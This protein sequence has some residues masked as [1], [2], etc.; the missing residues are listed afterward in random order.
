MRRRLAIA[1]AHFT[2]ARR[3]FVATLLAACFFTA[4]AGLA[5]TP[6]TDQAGRAAEARSRHV[7][8]PFGLRMYA[9]EFSIAFADHDSAE[10]AEL[11]ICPL[12]HD[13]RWAFSGRWDD[14]NNR[15]PDMKELMR[16]HGYKATF[17]L[18]SYSRQAPFAILKYVRT[19][20][21]LLAQDGFSVGG[22]TLQHP[23]LSRVDKNQL[24][25][26]IAADRV[27][28]ECAVGK[29]VN[30]FAFP[31]S[32]F[33]Q[34]KTTEVR[35]DIAEALIRAGYLHTVTSAFPREEIDNRSTL[36]QSVNLINP[37][38]ENPDPAR[39]D[40]QLNG[41]LGNAQTQAVCPNMTVGIH[42]QHT[43]E[44]LVKLE[45]CL[46]RYAGNRG[47]WYCNQTEYAAYRHQYLA[48]KLEKVKVAGDRAFFRLM[49]PC[50]AD[51]G[52]DVP[53][54]LR[55]KNARVREVLIS[56]AKSEISHRGGTSIIN[57]HHDALKTVPAVID[58]YENRGNLPEAQ[59]GTTG[60]LPGVRFFI[61]VDEKTGVIHFT[62]RNDSAHACEGISLLTRTPL[63]YKQSGRRIEFGTLNTSESRSQI[64]PLGDQNENAEYQAGNPYFIVQ[65]DFI[66]DG[67][68]V[69]FYA[70]AYI[71]N[72]PETGT[73]R[74]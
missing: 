23:P 56:T 50:G 22:H 9:Q 54:S 14:C 1:L 36:V 19:T 61:R 67:R 24:F 5:D 25:R 62:G 55:V 7:P 13:A 65:A 64:I 49:R 2:T 10:R 34:S 45:Q 46:E 37:G 44:G 8:N 42:V 47:W 12:L 6:L 60:E 41:Y 74:R 17:Y 70:T 69:R 15:N 35:A 16:K 33:G 52:D 28:L 68:P 20:G 21:R 39:F 18:N 32:D 31:G 59:A 51:L 73:P 3:C 66:Y 57:V 53:L 71:L 26:Q 11:E 27:Y 43:P 72:T 30:S 48:G 40:S 58:M 29:P 63:R 38:D 4:R